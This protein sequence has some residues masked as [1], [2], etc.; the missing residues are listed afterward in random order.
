MR[1]LLLAACAVLFGGCLDFPEDG[2]YRCDG[3]PAPNC[4]D[5]CF[6][7]DS[8]MPPTLDSRVNSLFGARYGQ[9]IWV[10]ALKGKL[11]RRRNGEWK[12]QVDYGQELYGGWGREPD[13]VVIAGNNGFLAESSGDALPTLVSSGTSFALTAVWTGPLEEGW[14]VGNGGAMVHRTAAGWA[15][16][17]DSPTAADL[18]AVSGYYVDHVWAAGNGGK[19]LQWDGETWTDRSPGFSQDILAVW[20]SI[21]GDVWVAGASG[22]S[23][24]YHDADWTTISGAGVDL[25]S[26]TGANPDDV[27]AGGAGGSVFHYEGGAWVRSHNLST[28]SEATFGLWT[29]QA[30]DLWVGSGTTVEHR[31]P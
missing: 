30:G 8:A 27:W 14:A 26:L 9:D 1:S 12:Q 5:Q 20:V 24:R 13:G 3:A 21:T 4:S 28:E 6:C 18:N 11:W 29:L 31:R 23:A 17:P 16:Y 7:P 2:A 22:A 10:V 25:V 19:V 15:P